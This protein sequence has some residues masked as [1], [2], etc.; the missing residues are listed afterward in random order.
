MYP[1]HPIHSLIS[2]LELFNHAYRYTYWTCL[3]HYNIIMSLMRGTKTD[4][5]QRKNN[6]SNGPRVSRDD[7]NFDWLRGNGG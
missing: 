4:C 2:Y 3:S 7:M 6:N 5:F 1:F